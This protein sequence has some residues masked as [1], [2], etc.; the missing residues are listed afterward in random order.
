MVY[1]FF[2]C[3]WLHTTGSSQASRQTCCCC[4]SLTRTW[5][6]F[7]GGAITGAWYWI[8][9][10]LRLWLLVQPGLWTLPILTWWSCLRFLSELVPTSKSLAWKFDSNLAFEDHV[11]GIVSRVSQRIG[12]LRLLKR[13][14][15]HTSVL[16]GCYFVFVLPTL[17]FFFNSSPQLLNVTFS[18]LSA[19]YIRWPDFVLIRVSCRCVIDVMLL[20]WVC[21]ARLIWTLITHCLFSYLP[22]AGWAATAGWVAAHPLELWFPEQCLLQFSAAQVLVGLG[23]PHLNNFVFPSWAPAASFNNN[24]IITVI[25]SC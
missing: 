25:L 22:S 1:I 7:R 12:I 17:Q 18:F 21:C 11:R 14:F 24:H 19:R 4:L 5:L 3:R 20:G 6:G 2:C 15:V 13:I 10:K 8:L 23:K 9:T 16:L